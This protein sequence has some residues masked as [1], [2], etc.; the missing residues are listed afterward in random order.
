MDET[1]DSILPIPSKGR[2]YD[3][4]I[5]Y[6]ENKCHMEALLANAEDLGYSVVALSR[7]IPSGMMKKGPKQKRVKVPLPPE[8]VA[9]TNLTQLSRITIELQEVDDQITLR[10]VV[11]QGNYDIIAVEPKTEKLFLL[12]CTQQTVDI[13]TFSCSEKLPF[14]FKTHQVHAAIARGVY[15][16]MC[17]APMIRDPTVRRHTTTCALRLVECCKSKNVVFS[18]NA[19]H[20]L[21]LR[22]PYDVANLGLLFALKE[23]IV[24]HTVSHN[25]RAVVVHSFTRKTAKGAVFIRKTEND[26]VAT[27]TAENTEERCAKKRKMDVT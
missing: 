6:E 26:G 20:P 25:C 22:G 15:F 18:S 21:E 3:L 11:T 7:Y 4:N 23:N 13:I 24:P 5:P 14:F 1:L 2:H 16:E 8:K 9:E 27:K 19:L 10:D 17:Y 12:A